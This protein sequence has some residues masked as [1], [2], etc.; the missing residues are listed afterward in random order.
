MLNSPRRLLSAALAI[1]LGVGFVAASLMLATSMDATLRAAAGGAIRDAKVVLTQNP[2]SP[3]APRLTQEYVDALAAL[4][5]VE[6]VRPVVNTY[7]MSIG[8][9]NMQMVQ[10]QTVPEL[11]DR[12]TLVTG[13]LPEAKGEALVNL[14]AADVRRWAPGDT[15]TLEGQTAQEFT[16]VGVIDAASDTTTDPSFPHVFAAMADIAGL[17]DRTTYTD[18]YVHGAAPEHDLADAITALPATRDTGAAVLTAG[19]ASDLRVMQF[20]RG[21]EQ[22]TVML[23]AF[24]AIAVIVA[25]LVVANTFAILVAQ[26]TR[27]LALLRT[28]GATQGQVFRTVLIEAAVLGLV[29][30]L[31]GTALGAAAVAA[32]ARFSRSTNIMRIEHLAVTPRDVIAPV[33]VGTLLALGA[34]L[35]PARQATRVPPLAALR[36]QV[37]TAVDPRV[38]EGRPVGA[39]VAALVGFAVLAA[40][41]VAL[42]LMQVS[43]GLSVLV[44]IA[45]GLLSVTGVL[46]LGRH[47]VPAVARLVGAGLARVGGVPA[48]LAAENAVRNPGR[49]AATAGALLVGV[50]LVTMMTVGAATGQASIQRDLDRHYPVDVQ[51]TSPQRLTDAQIDRARSLPEVAAATVLRE[52]GAE[53]TDGSRW[54]PL[55]GFE[56]DAAGTLRDPSLAAGLADGTLL[57]GPKLDLADGATV[58]LGLTRPVTLTVRVVPALGERGAVTASTLLALQPEAEGSLGI[59]LADGVDPVRAVNAVAEALGETGPAVHIMSAAEQRALMQQVIDT[60]L[61][62]ALGLLGVAVVIAIVG[63]GNTLGLSVHERRQESGLLRAM[64]LTRAQLR[65]SL[66]WEAVLLAAVAVVLGL[67]LGLVYGFAGVSSLILADAGIVPDVPWLR[68][69]LIAAV[70]LVAGWL[71]SVL[72][73]IRAAKVPPAAALALGE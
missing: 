39:L 54:V 14:P 49:A 73:S 71:A 51:V 50:T 58:A 6:R 68:L 23:L 38:R 33:V 8:G 44:G 65:A 60:V 61:L 37:A 16:V 19:E 11:T 4:P 3:E 10:L 48:E 41:A 26:R 34:A 72:P 7:A 5:G 13:R 22:L 70:A 52:S 40:G 32:I 35:V 45:G 64:G 20:T 1:V 67:V 57:A 42:P 18:V 63:I 59:R 62:V 47:I 27:Q 46:A 69:A 28:V 24:G 66:G 12:T 53:T 17:S 21:S 56:P 36:P 15:V 31:V 9:G 43:A 55:L 29:A 2:E 25:G 30:S